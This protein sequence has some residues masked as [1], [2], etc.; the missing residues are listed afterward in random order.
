MITLFTSGSTKEPKEVTHTNIEKYIQNSIKTI[1]LTESDI[2][3]DVFP[4]NVIAHYT[5]TC[6]PAITAKANY[7][8][9]NFNPYTY[10]QLF[11]KYRP[12][13]IS[14]IPRHWEL[15]KN[16][17]EWNNVDMS[18]VRYMVTGSGNVTQQMIDDFRDR[19][20]QTVSNWYGMTEM[21]PPVLVANN[22]LEFDFNPVSDYSVEFADDGECVINGF[23]TGDIFDV[24]NKIFL[25]RKTDSN[26]TTWKN[27]F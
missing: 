7:I 10:F 24:K 12:T 1:G 8:S 25:H 13:Y 11:N 5:V 18:C 17:K 23:H 14:L 27:N 3:L 4:S 22:S 6:F 9:A 20:V 16:T 19:G 2:V 15:L 21:P 26:G